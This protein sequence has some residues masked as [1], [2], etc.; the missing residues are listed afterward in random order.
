MTFYGVAIPKPVQAG[1]ILSAEKDELGISAG[2]QDRVIQVYE[3]LVYMDFNEAV[4][5]KQG[6]GIYEPMDVKLL[7]KLY[8]A[9]RDDFS[10]PTE[11]FHNDI[12]VRFEQGRE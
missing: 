4:L 11:V 10:E 6:H 2:L 9:Y 12:R 7:P 1:L 8:I 5:K 3:G